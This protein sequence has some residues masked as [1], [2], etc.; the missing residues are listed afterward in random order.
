[1]SIARSDPFDQLRMAVTQAKDL[2]LISDAALVDEVGTTLK[3]N[4]ALLPWRETGAVAHKM[5]MRAALN[6]S[7]ACLTQCRK[8]VCALSPQS[9]RSAEGNPLTRSM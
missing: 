6:R 2:V 7:H 8:M 1:M 3:A 9:L 4:C 5:A